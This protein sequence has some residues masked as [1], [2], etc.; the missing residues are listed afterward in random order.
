[1]TSKSKLRVDADNAF[2]KVQNRTSVQARIM[3]ETELLVQARDEKTA[4]LRALRLEAAAVG[5]TVSALASE[6]P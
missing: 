1:M 6:K 5:C 3:S 4:R 2:L